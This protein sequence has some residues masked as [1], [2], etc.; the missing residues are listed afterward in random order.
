MR[1]IAL[2]IAYDGSAYA[3]WQIQANA[4]TVQAELERALRVMTKHPVRVA[5]ASRTDAGVHAMGQVVVFQTTT[6]IPHAAFIPGLRSLLP[7]D[8]GVLSAREVALDFDPQRDALSKTYRYLIHCAAPPYPLLH[9]RVWHRWKGLDVPAMQQAARHMVGEHDFSAL[10][11]SDDDQHSTVRRVIDCTVTP[12]LPG[13]LWPH[14][15]SC[16]GTMIVYA[17]QGNGFLKYMVRTIVGTLVEVGEGQRAP[18]DLPGLLASRDR[19]QAGPCA[20]A[21]G[22]YL[23]RVQF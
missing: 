16:E 3:G 5:G 22:L 21:H 4:N 23:C 7:P 20:P 6:A 9:Q 19:T 11:A 2:T 12:V 1:A 14:Y 18:D 13:Q 8:I 17:C 10:S 15:V